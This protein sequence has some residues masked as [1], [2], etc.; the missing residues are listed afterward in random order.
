MNAISINKI[1]FLILFIIPIR[2]YAQ[3]FKQYSVFSFKAKYFIFENKTDSAIIIFNQ[4]F[5]KYGE[6]H[7]Y[8]NLD[9]LKTFASKN[10]TATVFMIIKNMIKNGQSLSEIID[11]NTPILAFAK[12]SKSWESL[13]FIKPEI[14]YNILLEIDKL[15]EV[16]QFV[17]NHDNDSCIIKFMIEVDS[18]NCTKV[19]EL[20]KKQGFPGFNKLGIY[21]NDILFLIM[22]FTTNSTTEKYWETYFKPLLYSEAIRGN[23]SYSDFAMITDR[24]QNYK[25]GT[26]I[27]GFIRNRTE[28]VAP[29]ENIDEVDIRRANL[30]LPKLSIDA[31]MKNIKLP[32]DYKL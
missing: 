5:S 31:K 10:D 15:L 17:R 4:L 28:Y 27:Y 16:D 29:I 25:K 12:K 19:I 18:V 13:K 2:I 14:D 11:D 20:I 3:D 22:H 7:P 30:G 9:A 21:S 32:K 26:Q 1:I 24:F 8:D 23:I 6:L